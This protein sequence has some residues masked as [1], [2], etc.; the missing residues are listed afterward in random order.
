MYVAWI[1]KVK[2]FYF[3][4]LNNICAVVE[5]AEFC[6][7]IK[8]LPVSTYEAPVRLF[9]IHADV[10]PEHSFRKGTA[11]VIPRR[12]LPYS[13]IPSSCSLD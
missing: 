7:V 9:R 1:E 11:F 5:E 6:Q 3:S 10:F 4:N 12:L 8:I 13:S 2:Y